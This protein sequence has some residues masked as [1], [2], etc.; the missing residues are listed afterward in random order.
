MWRVSGCISGEPTMEKIASKSGRTCNQEQTL[1]WLLHFYGNR[2]SILNFPAA[3]NRIC[4]QGCETCPSRWQQLTYLAAL[5][6]QNVKTVGYLGM[7]DK[8]LLCDRGSQGS[9]WFLRSK[10]DSFRLC[11]PFFAKLKVMGK[12]EKRGILWTSGLSNQ[13]PS[14]GLGEGLSSS[15]TRI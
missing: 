11:L 14:D 1:N 3:P 4:T 2:H 10:P 5:R 9:Q 8:H 13:H 15:N 7:D 12:H 6:S